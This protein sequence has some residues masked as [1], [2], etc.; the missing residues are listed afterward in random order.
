[1][2][3]NDKEKLIKLYFEI[4]DKEYF[5]KSIDEYIQDQE[6]R[7]NKFCINKNQ[8]EQIE[9]CIKL[10]GTRSLLPLGVMLSLKEE[11]M[12]LLNNAL[13]TSA[14]IIQLFQLSSGYDH[15]IFAWNLLPI[16]FSANKMEDIEKIFPKE[17]GLSN[18]GYAVNKAITNLVMYLYYKEDSWREQALKD[19]YAVLKMKEA[20]ERKAIVS[21]LI[22]LVEKDFNKF[23]SELGN[24]CRGKKQSKL[25]GEN[26]FMK[27]FSFYSLGLYNFARYIYKEEI[28]KISIPDE[29]NFLLDL[30]LYQKSIDFKQGHHFI[31]FKE[32]FELF[33]DIINI[34]IPV[35][36]IY[37]EKGKKYTDIKKYHEEII[38]IL[39][40]K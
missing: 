24:V 26:E 3:Q 37:V 35:M 11:N 21:C 10:L 40:S 32:P 6:K 12:E 20:L 23:S 38:N 18:N 33:N 34:D 5:Y 7:Y 16:L 8:E 17:S 19:G 22:S 13:Y 30:H 27:H 31:H 39:L 28:G 9:R 2:N 36:H 29:D 14:T 1:M 4:A 25:L 15:C